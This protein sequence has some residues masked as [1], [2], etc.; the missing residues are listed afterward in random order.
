[1]NDKR[2]TT[3]GIVHLGFSGFRASSPVS[4]LVY[5]DLYISSKTKDGKWGYPINMG[6]KINTEARERFLV[7]SPDGKYLFFMRHTPGQDFFWVS[8]DIIEKL[9]TQNTRN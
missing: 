5:L 7:V 6:D 2:H 9:K 3:H 4:N 1:M 8:P